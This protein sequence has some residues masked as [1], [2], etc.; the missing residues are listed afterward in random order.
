MP[1]AAKSKAMPTRKE[2]KSKAKPKASPKKQSKDDKRAKEDKLKA[3]KAMK[4]TKEKEKKEKK[5]AK[6]TQAG[7]KP[8]KDQKK[9]AADSG[10]V[11]TR[12]CVYSR[13]YHKA[14][15][16]ASKLTWMNDADAKKYAREKGHAALTAAGFEPTTKC[17]KA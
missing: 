14:I 17:A 12:T 11:M 2:P 4:A 7:K 15:S 16:E 5:K 13:A 6:T 1:A 10:L 8:K 9:R 3:K